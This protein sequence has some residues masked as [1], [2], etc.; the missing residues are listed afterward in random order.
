MEIVNKAS[1]ADLKEESKDNLNTM[2]TA[3]IER[4]MNMKEAMKANCGVIFKEGELVDEGPAFVQ[5]KENGVEI[6]HRQQMSK[7][8]YQERHT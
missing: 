3:P 6:T 2:Q 4:S 5:F 8:E 1:D 7:G